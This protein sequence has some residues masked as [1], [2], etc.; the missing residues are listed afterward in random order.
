MAK[1]KM[2]LG[3]NLY[4][5]WVSIEVNHDPTLSFPAALLQPLVRKGVLTAVPGHLVRICRQ[6]ATEDWLSEVADAVDKV[7]SEMGRRN[8]EIL[9][10]CLVRTAMDSNNGKVMVRPCWRIVI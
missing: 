7:Q 5:S 3:T 2:W 6:A 4:N 9:K 1:L 10:T 8:G